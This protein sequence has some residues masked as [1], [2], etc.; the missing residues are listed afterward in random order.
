MRDIVEADGGQN[1]VIRAGFEVQVGDRPPVAPL[2]LGRGTNPFVQSPLQDGLTCRCAP[3]REIRLFLEYER[4][5]FR[6]V[7]DMER[8]ELVVCGGVDVGA[9]LQQPFDHVLVSQR[10]R[11]M[12]RCLRRAVSLGNPKRLRFEQA[13]CFFSNPRPK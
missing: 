1:V 11:D 7:R 10:G 6:I 9:M 8:R 5:D 13:K 2:I 12:Q 4:N 3:L